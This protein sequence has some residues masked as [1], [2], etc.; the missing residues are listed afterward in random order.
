[1]SPVGEK[2]QICVSEPAMSNCNLKQHF[3]DDAAFF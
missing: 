1:M 2:R 3:T